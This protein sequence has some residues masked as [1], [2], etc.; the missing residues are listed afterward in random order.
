VAGGKPAVTHYEVVAEYPDAGVSLLDV[1]LA[2]G[3]THQIRV[4]MAAIDHPV[5]GDRVYSTLNRPVDTPRIFLHAHRVG[6]RHP[7]TGEEITFTAPLPPDLSLVLDSLSG[8]A[9]G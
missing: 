6:L 7:V 3:R 1:A 2:T 8:T 9:A 4:H 5:V